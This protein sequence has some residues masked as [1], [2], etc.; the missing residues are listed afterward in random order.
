[1][2]EHRAN[3]PSTTPTSSASEY[4]QRRG[5]SGVS[6]NDLLR[7]VLHAAISWPVPSVLNFWIGISLDETDRLHDSRGGEEQ[8]PPQINEGLWRPG[9]GKW[10]GVR[11]VIFGRDVAPS[12][13]QR[14]IPWVEISPDQDQSRH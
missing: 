5:T 4:A 9:S 3:R 8:M 13:A 11:T 1:M 7:Y 6:F 2:A 12:L 14:E 10:S